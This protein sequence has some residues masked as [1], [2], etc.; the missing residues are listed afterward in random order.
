ML[1]ILAKCGLDTS[2]SMIK[3]QSTINIYSNEIMNSKQEVDNFTKIPTIFCAVFAEKFI[4]LVSNDD[5][6]HFT[7]AQLIIRRKLSLL[8]DKIIEIIF[9]GMQ[10]WYTACCKLAAHRLNII[11]AFMHDSIKQSA[12]ESSIYVK[13]N[14][15]LDKIINILQKAFK[16]FIKQQQQHPDDL[17]YVLKAAF[18]SM[19]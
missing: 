17:Q 10:K 6:S 7:H 1:H 14:D 16:D 12:L 15:S 11:S 19:N 18:P 9:T 4:Q 2:N 8:D 13:K 5:D 3:T